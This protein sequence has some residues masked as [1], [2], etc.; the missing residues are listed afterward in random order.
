MYL[1]TKA[2]TYAW[3]QLV[4][5]AGLTDPDIIKLN[6][7]DPAAAP[8]DQPVMTIIPCSPRAGEALLQ[9]PPQSLDWIPGTAATPA[10]LQLPFSGSIPILFW[11]ASC[12]DPPCPFAARLSSQHVVFYADVIAATFFMLSR[13]EET[14]TPE[15][16]EHD[17]FPA[18]A[19]VAYRQGFLTRPVVDE[20]ALI[21]R[22]WL[23]VLLPNWQPQRG[24]FSVEIS[25]DIDHVRRFRHWEN[26][27]RTL[28][29]DL[30][31]HRTP[32]VAWLTGVQAI[33]EA[34]NPRRAA[35][36]QHIYTLANLSQAHHIRNDTFYFMT[37]APGALD[38]EY[39]FT[40]PHVQT[41]IQQLVDWGFNIGLHPSYHT[42]NNPAM[43]C[44]EKG[45]LDQIL[46][47]ATNQARQHYLRF[48]APDSWRHY[49]EAGLRHSANMAYHDYEGFRCGTC[50][51][52]SPFD[53]E[54]DQHF[55]LTEHP[56]II[57][58]KT[59]QN[60]RHLT[61]Q[62]SL[63]C[64]QN[65]ALCCQ[66]VEGCFSL[67]WHNGHRASDWLPEAPLYMQ[68][69]QCLEALQTGARS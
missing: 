33:K 40:A 63:E 34:L 32:R 26:A 21:L 41:C 42:F 27:L 66:Q 24:L 55:S 9:L 56:L 29:S 39:R 37:S 62:Q 6:Y 19:S 54:Q 11:G 53:W 67:L 16:D 47:Q 30:C 58:D 50:H 28:V 36:Y 69:L 31:K 64:V 49:Q 65:Y 45:R 20:Y 44:E 8:T 7:G 5:R 52:F 43:L 13:W 1:T 17:R 48:A 38:N 4:K 14:V 22:T 10:H 15:R 51:P 60:Y 57:M 61:P 23:R 46:P 2:I 25:H 3:Q 59:L 12:A 68:I 35:Y 18:T